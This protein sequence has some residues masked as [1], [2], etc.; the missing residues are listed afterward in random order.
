MNILLIGGGGREHA[1]A[2][3]IAQSPL[4]EA[5]YIA[6]GN[7]GTAHCGENIL[8]DPEDR[9]AVTAFIRQHEIA[10]VVPG[11]EAPLV[12]GIADLCAELGVPCCGPSAV[13]SQLEGSKAFMKDMCMRAGV[14]TAGYEHCKTM[15]QAQAAIEKIGAPLV[16]KADGLAAG[17]GV[18]ICQTP[19][20]A[21]SAARDMLEG[22][23]FGAAGAEVVIE[24]FL[25]GEELSYFALCDG[26]TVIPLGTAQDHKRAHDGDRGPNTGGM[27]AYGP[28]RLMTPGLERRI[29]SE[30][31]LPMVTALRDAGAPF[32]GILFAGLMVDPAGE[33]KILEYN[34]RFGDP[35]CQVLMMRL[36]S[37]LV[38]LFLAAA[39]GRLAEFTEQVEWR[40]GAALTVVMA[41][42]GYP[43][44]YE[45]G[46]EIRGLEA[47]DREDG[48]VQVFHAGTKTDA[49][50]RVLAN[51]GRVLAVTATG[52]S[53]AVA[54]S[55]A[56]KA[57]AR[58]DWPDG[59]Y[60]RDIGWRAVPDQTLKVGS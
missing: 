52:P 27:G 12:D 60:R 49:R 24:E 7:A 53:V 44:A 23:T 48:T 51:G 20:Q 30:T 47:F 34:V 13:A 4:C 45:K 10:L 37:D 36:K 16:V 57:A 25:E 58:I 28:A 56:Y 46:S 31:I 33:P 32:T 18:I 11:P 3:K 54:Q 42:N 59:F 43:G 22:G 14:T 35:E 50:G 2:W 9:A 29:L 55:E 8:L 5:L 1:L 41:A 39:Q 6:P 19:E 38:E 40:D 15:E 26:Q 17:K 21:Q